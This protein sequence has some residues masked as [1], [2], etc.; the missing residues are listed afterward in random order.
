MSSLL[1]VPQ[2]SLATYYAAGGSN[3]FDQSATNMYTTPENTM[4]RIGV[5]R[6]FLTSKK[7]N[8]PIYLTEFSFLSGKGAWPN[9]LSM[10]VDAITDTPVNAG[11][12]AAL[13][14]SY[15][16][17]NRVRY[18][19][20]G[21]YWYCWASDDDLATSGVWSFAGLRKYNPSGLLDKP[22]LAYFAQTAL[23]LEGR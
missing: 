14:L 20:A 7:A 10:M 5:F 18:N 1:S 6:G 17:A 16:V 12:R 15:F 13:A 22:G 19:L 4:K 23:S 11:K 9:K 8:P 21:V 2:T 3:T